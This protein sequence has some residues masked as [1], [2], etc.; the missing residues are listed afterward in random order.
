ME[1]L[2][3]LFLYLVWAFL[4]YKFKKTA[5][6]IIP[7]FFP[8]Y[9][10]RFNIAGLPIYFVEGLI[11]IAA[12]PIFYG[13]IKG[14]SEALKKGPVH[15]IYNI[16]KLTVTPQ[17]DGFKKF[18]NSVYLPLVLFLIASVV[19]ALIVTGVFATH[20][21]GILKSWVIIPLI[22]FYI[23][24]R[25]IK[26]KSDIN[27]VLYS[28]IGS[29]LLLSLFGL[30]Q[31]ASGSYA[32]IDQ[33]VSG[34]FESAN[35]LAIYL[36]PAFIFSSIRYL[37]TFI[38]DGIESAGT[39]WVSFE[40]RIFLGFV[41]AI[42]FAL[43]VLT[44][45]YGAII[46]V[47]LVL[48]T[49][50]TVE[51]FKVH[52]KIA[53]KF[54]NRL[55]A[56]VLMIIVLGTTVTAS[57]NPEKFQNLIKFDEHTSIATRVEIWQVGAKLIFENPILGIGLGMYEHNYFVRA[58]EILGHAPLEKTR[59]HSHNLFME[60]WLNSGL[61]GLAT[62]IWIVVLAFLQ[63]KKVKSKEERK[64]LVAVLAMLAYLM[65]HGVLD[66]TFWKNDLSLIFFMILGITFSLPDNE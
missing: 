13:L 65:I 33:R 51:R 20:A 66:V 46:G 64:I 28:Y 45:S 29:A 31:A 36:S 9:L 16:I 5:I 14:D 1:Y 60:T 43:L 27:F 57:L 10:L 38:H 12:I 50:I 24:H 15:K 30:F 32:T 6:L 34:P 3:F 4:V 56:F 48:F 52:D 11:L 59:L 17:Q 26:N 8:L 44:Q 19:G 40:R 35:Y 22:Y 53:R 61:L 2:I 41:V 63:F 39:R 47:F 55:I 54:L 7:L 21:L 23:L 25:S 42:L 18:L 49:Y 37:Q 62:F 58:E